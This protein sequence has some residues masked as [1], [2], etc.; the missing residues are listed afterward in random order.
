MKAWRNE[1]DRVYVM[2]FDLQGIDGQDSKWGGMKIKGF[3]RKEAR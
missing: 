1:E 2:A 3:K